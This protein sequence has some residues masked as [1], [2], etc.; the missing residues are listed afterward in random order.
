VTFKKL[1]SWLLAGAVFGVGFV[2]AGY[3][4]LKVIFPV[5]TEQEIMKGILSE[6]EEE[7]GLSCDQAHNQAH[8]FI[9]KSI[10]PIMLAGQRGDN[11]AS[12]TSPELLRL[13]KEQERVTFKCH[14]INSA[15]AEVGL[16]NQTDFEDMYELFSLLHI[17]LTPY[18]DKAPDS[19]KFGPEVFSKLSA[20]YSTLT[21]GS[22]GDEPTP[23]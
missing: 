8:A 22:S 15:A 21:T 12:F 10:A 14:L 19:S 23:K 3:L 5:P 18:N 16:K 9:G 4:S 1:L 2:I 13:L 20:L 6:K 11:W 17:Y 7:L